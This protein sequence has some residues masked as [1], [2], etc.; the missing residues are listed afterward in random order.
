MKY[1]KVTLVFFGIILSLNSYCQKIIINGQE[2]KRKLTWADFTG[3]VEKGSSFNAYTAYNFNTKIGSIKIIGDS[4]S[5]IGFEVTLELDP[6][7]SWA[8]EDKVT[9]ELLIHEQGHFN[10]GIL[11]IKE[12]LSVFHE[13]KFKKSNYNVTLQSIINDISKKYNDMGIK[14]DAET[15]HSKNKE[16]QLVW[17]NFF[18]EKLS[19]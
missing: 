4:V 9:D 1:I 5:I 19:E 7:K 16:Q 3:K 10:L 14:Y 8:K 15:N 18:A 6:K 2:T 13:T 17:N 12:I 11:C